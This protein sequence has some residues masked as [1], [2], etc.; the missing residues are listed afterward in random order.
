[1]LRIVTRIAIVL[2]LALSIGALFMSVRLF[3]QRET[4]KGRTQKL[5][6][7]IH[8]VA[9]TIEVEGGSNANARLSIPDDQLKT[10]KAVKNG[11]ATTMDQPLNQLLTAAQSQ[12]VKLNNTRGEL[13]DTKSTLAKTQEELKTTQAELAPAKAKI[14]EHEA[15]IEA[16]NA[17]I[18]EKE[19]VIK[20]LETE[21][22][23]LTARIEVAQGQFRQAE[24]EGDDLKEDIDR[25]ENEVVLLRI[26]LDPNELK[27][28]M[29]KGQQGVVTYVNSNWNF[30]I[31]RLTP[32]CQR[33]LVPKFEFMIYRV[34]KL[35]GKCRIE[36]IVDNLAVAEIVS[37][38]QQMIPRN[39]D[40][41]LY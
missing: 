33:L 8:K 22:S 9:A 1:M 30:L 24:A 19:A 16:K 14:K 20:N 3:Q 5:E 41:I 34:D 6:D 18:S 17:V 10:Y 13:A 32:E 7:A 27:K 12:L 2:I 26:K 29:P 37:D 31:V 23:E 25:V 11:P 21:K 28:A 15:T 38:W 40:G 35:V 36:S 39:G 4:L